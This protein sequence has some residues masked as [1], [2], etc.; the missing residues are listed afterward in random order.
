M[1]P[2]PALD[3]LELFTDYNCISPLNM[4]HS[5]THPRRGGPLL[6]HTISIIATA[7]VIIA[8][9]AL[10]VGD[11]LPSYACKSQQ[12]STASVAS[13]SS[14]DMA[15]AASVATANAHDCCKNTVSAA[16]ASYEKASAKSCSYAKTA[17]TKTA[18]AK[19][20]SCS[21]S[22]EASAASTAALSDCCKETL[23]SFEEACAEYAAVAS[24]AGTYSCSSKSAST[25]GTKTAG[26]Y[27][28]TR[29]STSTALAAIPYSEGKKV[30]LTGSVACGHC[31][32]E[33]MVDCGA[34][35]KTADGKAYLIIETDLVEKMREKD[36]EKG[37][38]IETVVRTV[39]GTKYLEV[40]KIKAL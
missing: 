8:V 20:A 18:S 26:S 19:D 27:S 1:G 36:T 25:A 14:S 11:P 17:S 3:R 31:D 4:A 10:G 24:V 39:D 5:R 15:K 40:E 2:R 34:V 23:A 30:T 21:A 13:C 12:A 29:G 32:L 22:K 9:V 33:V 35:F 38:K 6:K 7:V 28:C 16:I 37:Y